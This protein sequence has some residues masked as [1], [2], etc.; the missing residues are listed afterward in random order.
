MHGTHTYTRRN[1]SWHGVAASI[2]ASLPF[3]PV[4]VITW[5]WG[6]LA[7]TYFKPLEAF[8]RLVSCRR[9]W[10]TAF[11][12]ARPQHI[13]STWRQYLQ[14]RRRQQH[15]WRCRA[16]RSRKETIVCR[17]GSWRSRRE[18]SRGFQQDRRGRSSS[19]CCHPGW[20][21]S[22]T[23]RNRRTRLQPW[24]KKQ[25]YCSVWQQLANT[26]TNRI[27]LPSLV[28]ID[29][30]RRCQTPSAVKNSHFVEAL[31][32]LSRTPSFLLKCS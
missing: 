32:F 17:D 12:P 6:R 15:K 13:C 3:L 16:T 2:V 29:Q 31:K 19:T 23:Y 24:V 9:A 7:A 20:S 10:L 18:C 8:H 14:G 26:D 22:P 21:S 4:E 28:N 27:F 5:I 1:F 30:T 25:Q 11:P